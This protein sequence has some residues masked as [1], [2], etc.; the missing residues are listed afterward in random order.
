MKIIVCLICFSL[1]AFIIYWFLLNKRTDKVYA[2][3]KNNLQEISILVKGGYTPEEI[4]L[5]AKIP[6]V[7]SFKRTDASSCLDHVIFP[8]LGVN[9]ELPLKQ[10]IKISINT[11]KPGIYHWNCDMNMFHGKLIIK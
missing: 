11:N 7:L 1:I 4:V 2:K 8:E 10:T 3:T 9:C 6:A 5:K